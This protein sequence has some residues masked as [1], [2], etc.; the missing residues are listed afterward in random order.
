MGEAKAFVLFGP[1][2]LIAIALAFTTP[3]VLS[4]LVRAW[5]SNVLKRNIRFLF[6]AILIGVWI[7]WYYMFYAR[8][9]ITLG[10]ALPMN[11]CD[12]ATAA[13]VVT[14]LTTNQKAYELAYFWALGGTLQGVVTPDTPYDFPDVRFIIFFVYHCV[15]IASVL[16]LTLGV[17]MRP[18]PSSLLRVV[19]FSLFYAACASAV[20][21]LLGVNYGFFRHKPANASLYDIMPAW[22]WYIPVV[23]AIGFASLLIYY[24]PFLLWDVTRRGKTAITQG[25]TAG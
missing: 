15:I 24:L 20:D 16:Y 25:Q 13:T 8:G 1:S 17:K 2:H 23:I 14:L 18:Y 3:L 22:P 19:A 6:A 5:P 7:S 12:W 10:N 11:L 21:W 4:I 9:W